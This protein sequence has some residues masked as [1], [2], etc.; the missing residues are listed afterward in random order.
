L[1]F[2]RKATST[3]CRSCPAFDALGIVF[4]PSHRVVAAATGAALD[5]SS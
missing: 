5:P 1:S 3:V 4:N 2:T